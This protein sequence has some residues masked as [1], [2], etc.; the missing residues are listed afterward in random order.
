[1]ESITGD[2]IL[3]LGGAVVVLVLFCVNL[4][5]TVKRGQGSRLLSR[6]TFGLGVIVVG[7]NISRYRD[8]LS[9]SALIANFI[10]LI[11]ILVA[12]YRAEKSSLTMPEE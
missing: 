10:A 2:F 1:M 11:C 5:L 12:W 8:D 7:Y 9:S 4:W 3:V 6:M